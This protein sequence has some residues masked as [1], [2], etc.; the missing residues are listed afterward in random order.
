MMLRI[1][2]MWVH[3]SYLC[4]CERVKLLMRYQC[5]KERSRDRY[6]NYSQPFL[7]LEQPHFVATEDIGDRFRTLPH[8]S[9]PALEGVF[10]FTWP[11]PCGWGAIE[12]IHVATEGS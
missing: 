10:L 8:N 11:L 5:V 4:L 7:S 12:E 3:V 2:C 9:G 1:V 6:E